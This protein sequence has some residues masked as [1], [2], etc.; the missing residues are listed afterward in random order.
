MSRDVI[1]SLVR[2]CASRHSSQ[3]PF[4]FYLCSR[5]MS[6]TSPCNMSFKGVLIEPGDYT[7]K[8]VQMY[9]PATGS[10]N[11]GVCLC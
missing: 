3:D 8:H 9:V 1:S 6:G 2:L 7:W 11:V 10:K 5:S 4:G